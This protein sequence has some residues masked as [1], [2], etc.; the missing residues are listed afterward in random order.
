MKHDIE[1]LKKQASIILNLYNSQN[2]EE[3]ISKG[4]ILITKFPNQLIFYNAVSLS[5]SALGKNEEALK[6]IEDA[7]RLTTNDINVLNNAGLINF[8]LGRVVE[9]EDYFSRALK[10]VK[11]FPDALINLGNL[12]LKQGKADQ[13]EVHYKNALEFNKM[14]EKNEMIF[15]TLGNYYQQIGNFEKA[16]YYY[17][18]VNK[19]NKNNMIADKSISLMHKY[20]DE[21]DPHLK[22]MESKLESIKQDSLNSREKIYIRN[23]QN[24][25]LLYFALGKAYEDIGNF[26]ESFKFLLKA[27]KIN[28]ERSNFNI[29]NEENLFLEIKKLFSKKISN[30]INCNKKIIFVV[31]M[32]R[33]GTTLTEQII[34]SHPEVHGAGELNYLSEGIEKFLMHDQKFLQNSIDEYNFKD[35]EYVQDYYITNLIK[36][37]YKKTFVVDKAP[38]NFRWIGFIKTIFPNAKIVHC[39]RDGMDICFSNFKNFFSANTLS[40]SYDLK[41]LGNYF[42]LYKDLMNYWL[43]IFQNEIYDLSYENL[44]NDQRGETK[45]LIDYLGLHW[46]EK[47]LAPHKNKKVVATASLAQVRN[48]IYKSS[49]KRW[50]NYSEELK[51]LQKL[52]E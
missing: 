45:K 14:P 13:A 34:S 47:C 18:E 12:K 50:Q 46:D 31:G 5:L 21:N 4:K 38:L 49:L 20:E 41:D 43:T 22:F 17:F 44:I 15:M 40:F 1:F 37:D 32:P 24:L 23:S 7:L 19:I 29:K 26:K 33:S 52:I 9:A 27:N 28:K 8:N 51:D 30:K 25:D 10:I 2:H 35:L 6:I 36:L 16:K 3:V 39:K 11:N 48:P 42:N